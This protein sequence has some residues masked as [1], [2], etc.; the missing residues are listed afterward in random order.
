MA[1]YQFGGK[2]ARP[3]D[4]LYMYGNGFP[5]GSTRARVFHN[6]MR[7]ASKTDPVTKKPPRLPEEAAQVLNEIR[8]DLRT[9]IW[10]TEMQKRTRLD[11]EFEKLE[12]GRMTHSDF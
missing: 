4:V 5:N 11:K 12:Q 2:K 3:I 8:N 10:E 7:R 6:H 9:Y 1:C